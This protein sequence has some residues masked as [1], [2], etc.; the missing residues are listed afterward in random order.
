MNIYQTTRHHIKRDSN[1]QEM[2][3]LSI[4]VCRLLQNCRSK[5]RHSRAFHR[6]LGHPL[7]ENHVR[8]NEQGEKGNPQFCD[9]TPN[10]AA[11]RNRL[12][13]Q[14]PSERTVHIPFLRTLGPPLEM[15]EVTSSGAGPG[16]S[17][18]QD[19]RAASTDNAAQ[20]LSRTLCA[21]RKRFCHRERRC[22]RCGT[23]S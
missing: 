23:M 21:R 13:Q 7:L 22:L 20:A 14:Q 1:L 19:W 6:K 12:M 11:A 15:S 18:V 4:L 3:V 10:T 17:P 9:V 5:R 8:H 16:T 2:T